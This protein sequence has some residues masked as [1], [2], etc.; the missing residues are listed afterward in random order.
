MKKKRKSDR[1][2]LYFDIWLSHYRELQKY[3]DE[4]NDI[5][6]PEDFKDST[7]F[8]LGAWV[9][10]QRDLYKKGK[11]DFERED[12]LNKLDMVWDVYI[13]KWEKHYSEVLKF[14]KRHGHIDIPYNYILHDIHLGEWLFRQKKFKHLGKLE[15]WKIQKLD[16]LNINWR[17]QDSLWESHFCL[18]EKYYKENHNLLIPV[19]YQSEK[20]NLG[21]WIVHQRQKYKCGRLSDYQIK[22]LESIGMVW[23]VRG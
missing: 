15:A 16:D 4:H 20:F 18:A 12:L 7:G 6:V 22:N 9:G 23:K 10:F 3:K 19:N 14:Y 8:C 5:L 11:L 13:A 2:A 21:G 17:I 1:E